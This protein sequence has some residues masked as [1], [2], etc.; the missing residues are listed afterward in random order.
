VNNWKYFFA[1]FLG[2][3][4][5]WLGQQFWFAGSESYR[6]SSGEQSLVRNEQRLLKL[7]KNN[8]K[9]IFPLSTQSSS[10]DNNEAELIQ[11]LIDSDRVDMAAQLFIDH[12]DQFS[13]NISLSQKISD[14]WLE[15]GSYEKMISFLYEYR[16]FVDADQEDVLLRRIYELVETVDRKLTGQSS[17]LN[18][19]QLSRLV[20]FYYMLISIHADHT[21]YYLRL[22]YWLIESGDIDRAEQFLTGAMNDI[23][24]Q[25]ELIS[26]EQ[27]IALAKAPSEHIRVPLTKVGEHYTL[28]L[29]IEDQALAN[30]MIDTGASMTVL[31][32]ELIESH[33][34][35]LLV[36]AK[37]L[38]MNTANGSVL[39]QEISFSSVSMGDIQI[40]DIEIG[41][42]QLP[43]F[44]F[45]GLL[46]MNIL[47]QFEF[48]IDQENSQLVLLSKSP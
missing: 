14:K 16:L 22:S 35:H 26:L 10:A 29:V 11:G 4:L 15:M 28:E 8:Q 39:G 17:P 42:M 19:R 1:L 43:N 9:Q 25:D 12:G 27:Q 31:K 13:Q 18:S 38:N 20:S 33:F 5:G 45:D 32:S 24:Y 40:N 6:L 34:S 36:D 7:Q 21:P 37:T 23:R 30:V 48:L 46:G 44:Q 2:L 41:V 47:S 3:V